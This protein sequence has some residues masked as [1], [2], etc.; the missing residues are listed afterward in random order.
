[1]L[2]SKAWGRGQ[3]RPLFAS[4]SSDCQSDVK[5]RITDVGD[6]QRGGL[7]KGIAQRT[8]RH[9]HQQ[10]Q[11]ERHVAPGIGW[12]PD[13]HS[14]EVVPTLHVCLRR[15]ART[16]HSGACKSGVRA[17]S[18][19]AAA[20]QSGPAAVMAPAMPDAGL[21]ASI[22]GDVT[23]GSGRQQR[24]RGTSEAVHPRPPVSWANK[25]VG[26]RPSPGPAAAVATA[27]TLGHVAVSYARAVSPVAVHATAV[28]EDAAARASSRG[29]S[30]MGGLE[31]AHCPS[32]DSR[33]EDQEVRSG[34]R[35]DMCQAIV[36]LD[37]VRFWMCDGALCV[38][39]VF[40]QRRHD[41]AAAGLGCSAHFAGCRGC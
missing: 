15:S 21:A 33:H 36:Q 32:P 41:A 7:W 13:Q 5:V 2:H 8:W 23:D 20:V 9:S 25:V 35:I 28:C 40:T 37:H 39:G 19:P 12:M 27:A 10:F 26:S 29:A 24:P 34:L 31:P 11:E 6:P 30:G 17:V 14:I 18:T 16:H 4:A 22:E 38:G 1:M 3:W